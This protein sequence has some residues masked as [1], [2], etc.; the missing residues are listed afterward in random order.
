M[1]KL[2]GSLCVL[3]GGGLVWRSCLAERRRQRETLLYSSGARLARLP[4]SEPMIS[5]YS[6]S[7]SV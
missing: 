5:S 4:E 2:L 6:P 7:L 1:L 3:S